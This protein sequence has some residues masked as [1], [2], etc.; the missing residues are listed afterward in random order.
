MI[1]IKGKGYGHGV[2]LSQ[3][4]A[5][6]MASRRYHYTAILNYYYHGIQ[7][8]PYFFLETNGKLE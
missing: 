3:E 6:E 8:V 1:R 7:I 4:G 5:L 2:G